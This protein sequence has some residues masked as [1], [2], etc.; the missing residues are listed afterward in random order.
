[1]AMA[2]SVM[3]SPDDLASLIRIQ[4]P[5]N[6]IQ[7]CYVQKSTLGGVDKA[8]LMVKA[9]LQSKNDW[10]NGIFHNSQYAMFSLDADDKLTLFAKHHTMP[11][12]RKCKVKSLQ[13]VAEKIA[14]YFASV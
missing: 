9:S 2:F 7:H 11:K 14:S 10:M 1:M 8:S 5:L 3:S 4:D 12:F 13:H 6:T